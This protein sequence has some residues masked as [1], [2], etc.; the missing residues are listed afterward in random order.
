MSRPRPV[1]AALDPHRDD[2]SAASLGLLL[3]RLTGAPLLLASAY[4]VPRVEDAEARRDAALAGVEQVRRRVVEAAGPTVEVPS[5]V[6][7]DQSSPARALHALAERRGAAMIVV[8]SSARGPLGRLHP[9][10]VTDRLLHG[11]PCPVAIATSGFSADGL[12]L[13]G[14]AF[15]ERPDGRAALAHGCELARAAGARARI[16]TVREPTN[17]RFSGPLEASQLAAIEE[18]RDE[19]A[20][21]AMSAGLASVPE[22]CSAGGEVVTGE[23]REVLAAASADLDLLVCGSR[24]HGPVQT[25][26]LGGVSHAIVREAA[27]PVLVVPLAEPAAATRNGDLRLAKAAP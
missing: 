23:P 27:C 9:G 4:T 12:G 15:L 14:I 21:R 10:A 20:R 2:W 16:I 26:L 13:I 5:T 7:A 19:A 25:L 24:G 22:A 6:V 18:A 3:A 1:I 11:A 8:G 17:W